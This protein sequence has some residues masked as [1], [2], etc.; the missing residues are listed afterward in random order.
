MIHKWNMLVDLVKQT[1]LSAQSD[2][3]VWGLESNGQYSVK[4][5]YKMIDFGGIS[6]HIKDFISK[7]K[8][9]SNIH[10]LL[11]QMYNNKSL[12]RDNLAKRRHVEDRMCVF[13][14]EPE[15]IQHLLF[16]CIIATEIWAVIVEAFKI[17]PPASFESLSYFWKKRKQCEAINIATSATLW[18]LWP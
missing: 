17:T 6:S 7:I 4:S 2:S 12:T 16:D 15:S 5:F 11:W 14:A 8:V 18:F 1:T 10:I 9:P 3:P 13:C